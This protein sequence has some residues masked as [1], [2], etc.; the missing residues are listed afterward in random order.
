MKNVIRLGD[1]TSHGGRVVSA[2]SNYM[3]FGKA[4]ARVGDRCVC[5]IQGH[6]I[7][8]IVEGDSSWTIDGA[9]VALDGCKTSCGAS[10]I[11]TLGQVSGE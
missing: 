4:V 2:A 7:C 3:A 9:S 10:L 11:S 8:F 1:P 6:Q 5:P